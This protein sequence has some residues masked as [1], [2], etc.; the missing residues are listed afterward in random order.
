[1]SASISAVKS[2]RLTECTTLSI[3]E[4]AVA[5]RASSGLDNREV[6]GK[7]L[8]ELGDM[9]R[10]VKDSMTSLNSKG[11]NAFSWTLHSVSLSPWY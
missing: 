7:D 5:V 8:K 3:W 9:T 2:Q 6:L 1:V 10:D 4:L 11:I